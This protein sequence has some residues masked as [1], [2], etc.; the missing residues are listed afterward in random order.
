MGKLSKSNL[1][2]TRKLKIPGVAKGIKKGEL[3]VIK[4]EANINFIQNSA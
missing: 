4:E 1:F 2:E 3:D